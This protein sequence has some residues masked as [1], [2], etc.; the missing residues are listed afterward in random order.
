MTVLP[1]SLDT[2]IDE[3]RPVTDRFA[4]AGHRLYLVG[5]VVR[6][7]ML[8]LSGTAV[9]VDATTNARPEAIKVLLADLADAMWDQ[10]QRFGTIGA[11][12]SGWRY[13]ITTHRA[14]SYDKN[15]RKPFVEFG[16]D[17]IADLS[18]RDFTVNAMAV[19]L[20]TRTLIDPFGGRAD[21]QHSVLR[22][23]LQPR[24]S[25]HD[26]P[27]RMLRTARFHAGYGFEPTAA[28]LEVIP[29]MLARMAIVSVERI[30]DELQRLLM[31]PAPGRGLALLASTGLLADLIPE[32]ANTAEDPDRCAAMIARVDA[33]NVTKRAAN[34]EGSANSDPARRWAALLWDA[35]RPG[36]VMNSLRSSATLRG[37]VEWFSTARSVP[38]VITDPVLRGLAASTPRGCRLE[39][40]LGFA[41]RLEESR[42]RLMVLRAAEPDLDNPA[43]ALTGTEVL[44]E[45]GVQPGPVVG[46]ALA[47]LRQVRIASGPQTADEA[48][49]TL[50]DWWVD[51]NV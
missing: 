6:D 36:E 30:R 4:A 12:I 23:P 16:D 17:I 37:Q 38:D 43:A 11:V 27:L 33:V 35:E 14:E 47:W 41:D 45:L 34:L 3:M 13:E 32:L 10:G 50:R 46:E 48:K 5:G 24:E 39:D 49:V 21:L 28:L 44:D 8:G 29:T 26:D 40:L 18:R 1:A 42:E 20:S 31:L 19:D 7:H 15:S 51:R 9:D 25:F 22:T 2:T